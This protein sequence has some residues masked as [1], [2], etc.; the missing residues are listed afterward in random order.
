MSSN[1]SA[2]TET[3]EAHSSTPADRQRATPGLW[4]EAW[5]TDRLDKSISMPLFVLELGW[6]EYPLSVPGH[7]FGVPC[8]ALG[9]LPI[10]HS[11]LAVPH[12][13]CSA[14]AVVLCCV[15]LA[16]WFRALHRSRTCGAAAMHTIYLPGGPRWGKLVFLAAP[17]AALVLCRL[18]GGVPALRVAA[19]VQTSW[20]LTQAVVAFLKSTVKRP[21]PVA[22]ASL[23]KRLRGGRVA[24]IFPELQSFLR[25]A[26]ESRQSFPSGDVAGACSWA[27]SGLVAVRAVA[28]AGGGGGGAQAQALEL[29]L[30]LLGGGCT[31]LS[32][33]G[34]V[35]FHAHHLLDTAAGAAVAYA[36]GVVVQGVPL[37]RRQLQHSAGH[38]SMAFSQLFFIALF[39]VSKS[40][41]RRQSHD[42]KT[43]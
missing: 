17:H 5:L 6:W 19:F 25:S 13:L 27:L 1:S 18:T 23:A 21:R 28:A 29:L 33:L 41:L 3:R 10:V 35:Y 16:V 12:A 32:A 42:K 30:L 2:I 22:S 14:A 40:K 38:A 43:G 7:W 31:M 24:R 8:F 39:L 26:S 20:F 15:S 4:S 34:R 36:A 37:L 11:A 9:T